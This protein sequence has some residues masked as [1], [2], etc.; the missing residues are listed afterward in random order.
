LLLG[1]LGHQCGFVSPTRLARA[2]GARRKEPGSSLAEKLAEEGFLDQERRQLL[3]SLVGKVIEACEGDVGKALQAFGGDRALEEAFAGSVSAERDE[4]QSSPPPLESLGS[5]TWTDDVV[6][7]G[8]ALRKE[9]G[10]SSYDAG[11]QTWSWHGG[12]L[13]QEDEPTQ[14]APPLSD[15]VTHE[16]PGRYGL[17]N[18]TAFQVAHRRKRA[19][20]PDNA[21][22][23]AGGMG[24][25]L[26]A[27]DQHVGREIAIKE[28]KPQL[29]GSLA[30]MAGTH[31]ATVVARF[32]R[33]ARVTGVLEHPSIVPVHEVGQRCDGTYYYTMRLVRGRSLRQALRSADS[34]RDRLALLPHA[35]A[36]CHAI[37]Y[38]H[39][40][41]VLHRDIK[42]DNVMVGEFGE[43]VVL[44]WGLAEV[45]RRPEGDGDDADHRRVEI[46]DDQA[47][48]RGGLLGTPTHMAPEQTKRQPELVDEQSDIW[49]L[50]VVLYELLTGT[51]PA[52]GKTAGEILRWLEDDSRPVLPVTKRCADAPAE[53]ASIAMRCLARDKRQ[54]YRDARE[55]ARDIERYQAGERVVA[56]RYTSW[57][58]LSHVAT[59][60]PPLTIA[61]AVGALLVLLACFLLWSSHQ[62]HLEAEELKKKNAFEQV[63]LAR[64]ALDGERPLEAQARLRTALEVDDSLLARALWHRALSNP[65]VWREQFETE[66]IN[67]AFSPDDG[68]LAVAQATP[69]IAVLRTRTGTRDMLTSTSGALYIVAYSPAGRYLAAGGDK[70]DIVLWDKETSER[71]V[72]KAHSDWVTCLSFHSSGKRFLSGSCDGTIRLWDVTKSGVLRTYEGHE[73]CISSASWSPDGKSFATAG[74]DRTVRTWEV[75]SGKL[76]A[77]LRGHE[78]EATGV[79]YS[80][81]G[82]S[83]ISAGFDG[84]L[85]FWD[86][87]SGEQTESFVDPSVM[88]TTLAASSSKHLLA[89]GDLDG[90]VHVW[91]RPGSS[92]ARVLEG[93]RS[94]VF[95]LAFSGNGSWLASGSMDRTVNLWNLSTSEDDLSREPRGHEGVVSAAHY[96]PDKDLL[97]TAG[98]D[99][100]IRIWDAVT[101]EQRRVL[102]GHD[103]AIF[104]VRFA[105]GG[106]LLATGGA[107]RMVRLW[108]LESEE[109]LRVFIGHSDGVVSLSFDPGG[110]HLASGSYDGTVWL[111]DVDRGTGRPVV[112]QGGRTCA[113]FGPSGRRLAVWRGGSEEDGIQI[114]D[115]VSGR[116]LFRADA[117]GDAP[118]DLA[119]GSLG[120]EIYAVARSGD[121]LSWDVKTGERA[122]V[123]HLDNSGRSVAPGPA[124][125]YLAATAAAP[126]VL[127]H[128]FET[129]EDVSLL[130]H[131]EPVAASAFDAS[132]SRLATAGYDGTVRTWDVAKGRPF[133]RGTALL[134]ASGLRHSHLGWE[135]LDGADGSMPSS[136]WSQAV[137]ERVRL[138]ASSEDGGQLCLVTWDDRVELWDARTDKPVVTA[139][140]PGA[141][142]IVAIPGGCAL[143]NDQ[144]QVVLHSLDGTR[145]E[146]RTQANALVAD[147]DGVLV[148]EYNAVVVFDSEGR[149]LERYS[150]RS[151]RTTALARLDQVFA[152]GNEQGAVVILQLEEEHLRGPL[153]LQAT[154]ASS[155]RVL[156]PGLDSILAVG[157]DNGTVG[158]WNSATGRQLMQLRLHGPARQLAFHGGRLHALTEL[159][160]YASMDLSIF[161]QDYCGLLREVWEQAP[162]SWEGS[163][164][165]LRPPPADHR[166]S[167]PGPEDR[168][169]GGPSGP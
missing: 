142:E 120:D 162:V 19:N 15:K 94:L 1:L 49:A 70:G 101:G 147:G 48:P 80:A 143:R 108:D 136:R 103:D 56:H 95:S 47:P 75:E 31:P 13:G 71:Q 5:E 42:P 77:T 134:A 86:I 44:D 161:S 46:V 50:G 36:L 61:M 148:A 33:E 111:W 169:L 12:S 84:T 26:L 51:I 91:S 65:L 18:W 89:A 115:A 128:D 22:I 152:L 131:S 83:L 32:L 66:V 92:E 145:R 58:I 63:M 4:R 25:I 132:G 14:E 110:K 28:I 79:V 37:A 112:E 119:F 127:L 109:L 10:P 160:D 2:A 38:A 45:K 27:L 100:T 141:V 53:L 151:S 59:R 98:W 167:E 23:G 20:D 34:L 104:C 6:P 73:G 118:A 67:V 164:A 157:F 29:A 106:E 88:Y 137:E 24:R 62:A 96:S 11:T 107:D 156:V 163:Q 133:W 124:G 155:V 72:L 60:N 16:Q 159:G 97:A 144:G 82:R 113:S 81:D 43:T 166:C 7:E 116:V 158:L 64:A 30:P 140:A 78:D 69:D 117:D 168:S 90:G 87:A 114:L 40:R 3:E 52:E 123:A 93:H 150:L 154:P 9:D 68:V 41:G 105:P 74:S 17:L 76:G 129:G 153:H 165:V 54:R 125:R 21:T 55:V 122:V 139:E 8:E 130:A 146:L 57:E 149:E 102:R 99:G 138:G 85:R 39:S 35:A 121:V 126:A 135:R